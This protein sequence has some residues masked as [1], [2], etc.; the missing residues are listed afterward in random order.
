MRDDP[1]GSEYDDPHAIN[2]INRVVT[3]IE[4]ICKRAAIPTR[5]GVVFGV[6]PSFGAIANQSPVLTTDA[7]IISLSIPFFVFCAAI[8]KAMA[9]TLVY[10]KHDGYL[11]VDNRPD[12]VRAKLRSEPL[13]V[14]FWMRILR[15]SEVTFGRQTWKSRN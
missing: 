3:N 12:F 11:L 9:K 13:I 5:E 10:A 1:A 7:S 4:E 8:T 15:D 6:T 14:E 2:I